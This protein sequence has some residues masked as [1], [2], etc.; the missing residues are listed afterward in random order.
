MIEVTRED[1]LELAQR[2]RAIVNGE[3]V[4]MFTQQHYEAIADVIHKRREKIKQREY[5]VNIADHEIRAI[6]DLTKDL[7]DLFQKDNPKFNAL[8]F[9]GAASKDLA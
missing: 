3:Q 9:I 7:M 4:P 5:A 8:K 6:A 1:I 2:A